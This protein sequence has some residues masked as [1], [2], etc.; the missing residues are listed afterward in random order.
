MCLQEPFLKPQVDCYSKLIDKLLH[1]FWK[2]IIMLLNKLLTSHF[3][4]NEEGQAHNNMPKII[5]VNNST[6][7]LEG[8]SLEKTI[9]PILLNSLHG[10]AHY[11]TINNMHGFSLKAADTSV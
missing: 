6:N 8:P 11:N 3:W 7:C 4:T 9:I 10:F 1:Q 2:V 5:F